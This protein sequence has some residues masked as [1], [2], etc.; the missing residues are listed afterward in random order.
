MVQLHGYEYLDTTAEVS[1]DQ[2][3]HTQ[4][5]GEEESNA[6]TDAAAVGLAAVRRGCVA[7]G[8]NLH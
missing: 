6:A 2:G 7:T 8:E 3:G 5:G 4:L 1:R